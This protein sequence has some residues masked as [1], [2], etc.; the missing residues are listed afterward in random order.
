MKKLS[1]ALLTSSL[2]LASGLPSMAA[3]KPGAYGSISAMGTFIG[4]DTINTGDRV[5]FDTGWGLSAAV[6]QK[7]Q[8]NFR[9]EGEIAGRMNDLKH[10]TLANGVSYGGD[11]TVISL[12][13]NAYADIATNSMVTPYLGAGVG[14]AHFRM[15]E[16]GPGKTSNNRAAY[17][18][19]AGVNTALND[20]TALKVGYKFFS[21]F[22]KPRLQGYKVAYDSHNVELGVTFN[23]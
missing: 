10:K 22:N 18:L 14:Y 6:G 8:E 3:V 11:V 21:T 1:I 12:M 4:K 2:I 17:Q 13:A 16:A 23:F 19:M 7:Y 15:D 5:K 9:I 20:T